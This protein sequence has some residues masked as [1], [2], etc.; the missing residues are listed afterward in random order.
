MQDA[1]AAGDGETCGKPDLWRRIHCV[2]AV[3]L[4]QRPFGNV[5]PG[6]HFFAHAQPFMLGVVRYAP[7]AS[8]RFFARSLRSVDLRR[9]YRSG[10]L[11]ACLTGER[12]RA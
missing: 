1:D 10:L 3:L 5:H 4:A 12:I 6:G 11:T 8:K 7:A 9:R 2:N